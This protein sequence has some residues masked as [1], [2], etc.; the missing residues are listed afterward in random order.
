MKELIYLG[1]VDAVIPLYASK[2]K[3][4]IRK[5]M[6]SIAQAPGTTALP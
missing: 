3:T 1:A 2:T 4:K 6:G 5:N